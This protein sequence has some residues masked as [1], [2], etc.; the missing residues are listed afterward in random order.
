MVGHGL[1]WLGVVGT[2]CLRRIDS[3]PTRREPRSAALP[4]EP[5]PVP[6]QS[7]RWVAALR[8]RLRAGGL[9]GERC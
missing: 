9:A 4:T 2:V 8:D 6:E 3:D 5:E 7:P 1:T